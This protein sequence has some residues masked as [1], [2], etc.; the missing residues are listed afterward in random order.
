MSFAA[1]EARTAE[2]AVRQLSNATATPVGGGPAISVIFDRA[3][4]E[5]MGGAITTDGPVA[6]AQDADVAAYVSHSTQLTINGATLTLIDKKP[7]GTGLTLLI[8]EDA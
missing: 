6:L 8:L 2:V 3:T 7:D 5:A 4:I 1:A